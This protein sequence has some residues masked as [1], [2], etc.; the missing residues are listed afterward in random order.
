MSRICRAAARRWAAR[1]PIGRDPFLALGAELDRWHG[2]RAV[3][4]WRDDDAVAATPALDQLLAVRAES[5]VPLAIA[6]VP[7]AA[8]ASLARALDGTRAVRVLAHGWDHRDHAPPGAAMAELGPGRPRHQVRAELAAGHARLAGLF[9]SRFLPVLV[10]PYNRIAPALLPA[11]RH[12]GFASVSVAGDFT[13]LAM[14]NSNIHVDVND[15]RTGS[16]A[17]TGRALRDLIGAL[18]LRRL[19]FVRRA[20]PVG[21]LTHHLAHDA[22]SWRLTRALLRHLTTHGSVTFPPIEA[23]FPPRESASDG[24]PELGGDADDHQ[25]SPWY[26]SRP[27]SSAAPEARSTMR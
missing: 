20:T 14:P 18:R 23:I 17:D 24:A 26:V 3:L 2:A 22:A 25:Q 9:G 11:V 13:G 16:A 12:A 5:A 19:G 27:A 6:S 10:P 21:I 15:W 7:A 4:W 1:I 8:E